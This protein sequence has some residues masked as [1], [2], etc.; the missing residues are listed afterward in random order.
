M[1]LF[2]TAFLTERAQ[3]RALEYVSS[4]I[5]AICPGR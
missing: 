3:G 4:D 5:G 1:V 2:A